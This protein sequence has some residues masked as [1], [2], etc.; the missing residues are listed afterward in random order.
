MTNS[1][2]ALF[3]I[4]GTL[5]RGARC[6]YQ[7]FVHAVGKFYGMKEDISG[8]NYAGKTD[9]QILREVLELGKFKEDTIKKN[10]Q[11]CL[12]YMIQYYLEN[13]HLENVKALDGA[14]NLLN[15]LEKEEVLLG[16]TTGN[17]EPIAYAKLN[18]AGLD[19]YFPFG[20]FGSD[21]AERSLLVKKAI[22]VARYEFNF[23]GDEIF[24]IGDTPRDVVAGKKAGAKTIGVATGR[25]SSEELIKSKVDFIM[26]D[27]TDEKSFIENIGL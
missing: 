12:D 8:I 21:Y 27:L 14:K 1:I 4:D 19:E 16:L 20:G 23:K 11:N 18:R 24:V 10:F 26:D 15:L 13:V 7:A 9:P 5:V 25:Y 17:L 2:L 22:K 3:D 6:H